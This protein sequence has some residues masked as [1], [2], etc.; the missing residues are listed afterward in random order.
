MEAAKK[1]AAENKAK[2]KAKK[3]VKNKT[4]LES[5]GGKPLNDLVKSSL[6]KDKKK[7][8]NAEKADIVA[9][10]PQKVYPDTVGSD[11]TDKNGGVKVTAG[12]AVHQNL[13]KLV[14]LKKAYY[15]L[16]TDMSDKDGL[17]EDKVKNLQDK[18]K[19]LEDD[20]EK[21]SNEL[22]GKYSDSEYYN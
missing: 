18:M 8:T 7:L 6:E 2:K 4:G 13:E 1:K 14:D 21:L 19:K 16:E 9:N 11:T 12:L 10:Q 22:H 20:I 15:K 3:K 5:E 17:N